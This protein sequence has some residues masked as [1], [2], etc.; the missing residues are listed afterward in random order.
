MVD[1]K[2]CRD[3]EQMSRGTSLDGESK[4]INN[5]YVWVGL[6]SDF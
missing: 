6:R 2:T 3:V 5:I 1:A 4:K